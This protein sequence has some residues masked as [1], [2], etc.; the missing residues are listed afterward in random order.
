MPSSS[1]IS[2]PTADRLESGEDAKVDEAS[3][4]PARLQDAALLGS[5][6][7]DVA[8]PAEVG[9]LCVVVDEYFDRLARSK[10]P[11][12]GGRAVQRSTVS[13]I[14]VPRRAVF[15]LVIIGI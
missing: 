15:C 8:G 2:H 10:A 4:W 6:R 1:R 7:D 3:V 12:P 13:P 11:T 5:K 9:W 14:A